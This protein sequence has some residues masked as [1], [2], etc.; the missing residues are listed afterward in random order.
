MIKPFTELFAE[1]VGS[2]TYNEFQDKTGLSSSMLYD[3]RNWISIRK[4]CSKSTIV[5]ICVRYDIGLKITEELLRS[6]GSS[7]NPHNK[8]DFAYIT[9][10]TEYRGKSVGS[11]MCY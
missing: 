9:L 8:T 6:Q 11:V 1:I 5:S 4:P 7:F 3:L 2:D 10:L